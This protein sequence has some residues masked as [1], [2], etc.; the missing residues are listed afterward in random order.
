MGIFE[1]ISATSGSWCCQQG[2][3]ID[4][5]VHAPSLPEFFSGRFGTE[6]EALESFDHIVMGWGA[7]TMYKEVRGRYIA[8][9]PG[10]DI[11]TP[12]I[13][14][15]LVPT[16]LGK[17]QGCT[18]SI[19]VEAKKS[20]EKL[21]PAVCQALDYTWAEFEISD[22]VYLRPDWLG[23]WPIQKQGGPIASVLAQ[24]RILTISPEPRY[25]GTG[26]DLKFNTG[27]GANLLRMSNRGVETRPDLAGSIGR[28]TGSR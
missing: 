12:R 27:G 19:G 8:I 23:L 11:K 5:I 18:F 13:D 21:G 1:G 15:I 20:G 26:I 3:T 9:R 22:G 24:N 14:R 2:V 4:R 6:E 25:G 17:S 7:F 28:K 16:E 10:R